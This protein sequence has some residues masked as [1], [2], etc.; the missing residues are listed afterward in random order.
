MGIKVVFVHINTV[1]KLEPAW[2]TRHNKYL[3]Y[4]IES[5]FRV[6][7]GVPMSKPDLI[8]SFIL[9]QLASGGCTELELFFEVFAITV[10]QSFCSFSATLHV[11][12]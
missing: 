10:L 5:K 6:M 9:Y 8:D 1:Q 11:T 7:P 2:D 12:T 3:A 4:K